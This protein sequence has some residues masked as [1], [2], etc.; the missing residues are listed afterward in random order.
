V[1]STAWNTQKGSQSY[2]EKRRAKNEIEVMRR[3]EGES[4]GEIHI[5]PIISSL[6]VLHSSE[7]TKRFTELGREKKG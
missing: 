4:K 3:E 6:N 1:L 5:W 2:A 7:Y